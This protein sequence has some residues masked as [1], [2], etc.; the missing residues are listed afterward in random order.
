[1]LPLPN[2]LLATILKEMVVK[3]VTNLGASIPLA[4]ARKAAG[5]PA[6]K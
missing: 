5:G 2:G 1:M 3:M 4:E 6:K